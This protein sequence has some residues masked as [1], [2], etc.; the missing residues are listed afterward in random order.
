[1][2]VGHQTT[3]AAELLW[4][5]H[6]MVAE[7]G[8]TLRML[9]VPDWTGG[10]GAAVVTV[11][12]GGAVVVGAGAVVAVVVVEAVVAGA[13]DPCPPFEPR[14]TRA[15][16]AETTSSVIPAK[17]SVRGRGTR[18]PDTVLPYDALSIG[19]RTGS[20]LRTPMAGRWRRR[21]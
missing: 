9:G 17:N 21:R 13:A 1:M 3:R 12:T 8:P 10:G 11:V 5:C 16:T 6:A 7:Y 18:N 20:Y 14:C 19:L 15:P 2:P 4:V